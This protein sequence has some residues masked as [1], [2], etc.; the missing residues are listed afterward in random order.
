MSSFSH[1]NVKVT[2]F[3]PFCAVNAALLTSGI[4]CVVPGVPPSTDDVSDILSELGKL[5]GEILPTVAVKST[6]TSVPVKSS[7]TSATA[8]TDGAIFPGTTL[9][10]DCTVKVISFEVDDK[11]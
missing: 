6:A 10:F 9:L 3:L 2:V 5:L 7:S 11:V 8:V 4:V 1:S